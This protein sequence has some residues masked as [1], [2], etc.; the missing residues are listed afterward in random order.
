MI[1]A[2][3]NNGWIDNDNAAMDTHR[4]Q[5]PAPTASSPIFPCGMRR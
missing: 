5:A 1:I 3:A 4:L 2:A